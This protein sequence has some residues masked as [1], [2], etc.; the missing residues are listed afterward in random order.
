MAAGGEKDKKGLTIILFCSN[1]GS[2]ITLVKNSVSV[3]DEFYE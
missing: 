3:C 2:K 1:A